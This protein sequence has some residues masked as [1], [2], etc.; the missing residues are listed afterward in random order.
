MSDP[1]VTSRR[2]AYSSICGVPGSAS[3]FPVHGCLR[4]EGR[5]RGSSRR[6]RRGSGCV[7]VGRMAGAG[8]VEP[9][10]SN[11]PMMQVSQDYPLASLSA[12][13]GETL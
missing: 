6:L 3:S 7:R 5:S 1:A 9:M 11:D 10:L 12:A 4:D 13:A 8:G 2:Y